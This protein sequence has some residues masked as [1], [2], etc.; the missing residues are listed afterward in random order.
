MINA[1]E[2]ITTDQC[3][4]E[5][6]EPL[7]IIDMDSDGFVGVYQPD[8]NQLID[9]LLNNSKGNFSGIITGALLKATSAGDIIT[10]SNCHAP[11][12]FF[13]MRNSVSDIHT[14][15]EKPNKSLSCC[16][17]QHL[18]LFL[19]PPSPLSPYLPPSLPPD[20]LAANCLEDNILP[21]PS[22]RLY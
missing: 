8:P 18:L 11:I 16:L 7:H 21:F 4:G 13:Q 6:T 9:L 19:S 15:S 17:I 3:A 12:L 10:C 1:R 22:I 20:L 14:R 2:S 5:Y